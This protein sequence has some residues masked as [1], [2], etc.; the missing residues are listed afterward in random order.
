MRFPLSPIVDGYVFAVLLSVP[1]NRFYLHRQGG[2]A[3]VSEWYEGGYREM[4]DEA[5][6]T[7]SDILTFVRQQL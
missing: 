2:F 3:Y 1:D 7:F 5:L 6:P 4:L